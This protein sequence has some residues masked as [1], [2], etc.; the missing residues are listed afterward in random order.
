V[1][2]LQKDIPRIAEIITAI[3][4]AKVEE[5]RANVHKVWHRLVLV[6]LSIFRFFDLATVWQHE[7]SY[8]ACSKSF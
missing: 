8:R 3:P 7:H 2:I 5:M 4:E 6:A 1:R